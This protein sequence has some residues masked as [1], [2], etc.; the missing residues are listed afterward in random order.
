MA[1]RSAPLALLM[2]QTGNATSPT[3]DEENLPTPPPPP[4]SEPATQRHAHG[5]RRLRISL[6]IPLQ[7][8]PTAHGRPAPSRARTVPR[9][10]APGWPWPVDLVSFSQAGC[11][12][13]DSSLLSISAPLIECAAEMGQSQLGTRL[14]RQL[15]P[16]SAGLASFSSVAQ[17]CPIL[18]DPMNRSTPGLPVHHQL[19]EFTQTHVRRVSDAIQPSHAL[20]SPSPPAPNPSQ[21]Q[22]LFQW[23]NSSHEVAKV[24]E[25]QL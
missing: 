19:P 1:G 15:L 20:S 21:H 24:L 22:R 25:F 13:H 3:A 9:A 5:Q 12:S 11:D 6:V 8:P 10:R 16:D 17:S 2:P 23:V 18:G 14:K 4:A 7:A